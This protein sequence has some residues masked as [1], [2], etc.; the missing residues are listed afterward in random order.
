MINVFKGYLTR[1]H[2]KCCVVHNHQCAHIER[3]Y[4]H[5]MEDIEGTEQFASTSKVE[6]ALLKP[7][8]IYKVLTLA[9]KD[10]TMVMMIMYQFRA[11]LKS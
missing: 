5:I 11:K 6:L 1:L 4:D 2:K 7:K 9:F 10:T 8:R 3:Y